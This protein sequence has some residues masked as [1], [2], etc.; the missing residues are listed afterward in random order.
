MPFAGAQLEIEILFEPFIS[1]ESS[2]RTISFSG[3][4]KSLE[5]A[6]QVEKITISL[7]N[8]ETK[9]NMYT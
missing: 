9:G 5:L 1:F 3:N 6:R 2:T 7:L 4:L 8:S